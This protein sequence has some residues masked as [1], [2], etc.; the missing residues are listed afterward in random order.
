MSQCRDNHDHLPYKLVEIFSGRDIAKA[1]IALPINGKLIQ[2]D[3]IRQ[4]EHLSEV[5]DH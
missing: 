2:P 3:P 4:A 5:D 1:T